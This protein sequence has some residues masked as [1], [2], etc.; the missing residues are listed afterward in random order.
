MPSP[1]D[2]ERDCLQRVMQFLK[3]RV[4]AEPAV[5]RWRDHDW[6]ESLSDLHGFRGVDLDPPADPD[7]K[8][9]RV[10]LRVAVQGTTPC[11]A[12]PPSLLPWLNEGWDDPNATL[13]VRDAIQAQR[14][15]QGTSPQLL[16]G[17]TESAGADR[18]DA[19]PARM[20]ALQQWMLVREQWCKLEAPVRRVNSLYQRLFEQYQ[21]LRRAAERFGF[22]IGDFLLEVESEGRPRICHPVVRQRC[23][24]HYDAAKQQLSVVEADVPL[25]VSVDVLAALGCDA[26]AISDTA[27]QLKLNSYGLDDSEVGG[28]VR[29]LVNPVFTS[30]V[31]HDGDPAGGTP[32]E[33]AEARVR[34]SR[35]GFVMTRSSGVVEA[36]E[37]LEGRMEGAADVSSALL[38]ILIDSNAAGANLSERGRTGTASGHALLVKEANREQEAIVHALDRSGS[39]VVQGPPG[40]GKT[41][42]IA[43]VLG[44][45]LAQ[46]KSVLVTSHTSKA[47]RVLRD[48][49]PS[50]LQPLCVSILDQDAQSKQQLEQSVTGIISRLTTAKATYSEREQA[51]DAKRLRL[52]ERVR[53]LEVR[54]RDAMFRD[55]EPIVV[56]TRKWEP[57]EAAKW[58]AEQGNSF[59]WIPQPLVPSV[60]MPLSKEE[61]ESLYAS[62]ASLSPA[63]EV[64]L[65]QRRPHT[66]GLLAPD[67]VVWLMQRLV[68]LQPIAAGHRPELWGSGA[69]ASRDILESLAER[70]NAAGAQ[71]AASQGLAAACIRD[72]RTGGARRMLWEEY[73]NEATELI[74]QVDR[75]QFAVLRSQPQIAVQLSPEET[76][77]LLEELA[78]HVD[79]G[80]KL[81]GVLFGIKCLRRTNL[82][83]VLEA[84]SVAGSPPRAR[85]DFDALKALVEAGRARKRLV[86]RW[87][88]QVVPAGGPPIPDAGS[89]EDFLRERVPQ[90]REYVRWQQ[91]RF[92]SVVAEARRAGLDWSG[93]RRLAGIPDGASGETEQITRL[94]TNI[95]P[96]VI[97]AR[98]AADEV[99]QVR[100]RLVEAMDLLRGFQG[101]PLADSMQA[102][103]ANTDSTRYR[104][105]FTELGRLETLES[106]RARRSELLEKLAMAA[107]GWSQAVRARRVGFD[108]TAPVENAGQCWDAAQI[109]AELDRRGAID[110]M[111]TIAELSAALQELRQATSDLVENRSWARQHDR[112]NTE[113]RQALQGWMT[114]VNMPG[115]RTGKRSDT[116]QREAKK[117]LA[118]CRSA[119]PI[120]VMP[121]ARVFETYDF[122]SVHFDVVVVDEASQCDLLG[123]AAIAIGAQVMVVGDD[124]QVSPSA[125]GEHLDSSDRAI[126]QYLEGISNKH[127]FTGRLSLYAMASW[128]LGQPHMLTEH[129]RCVDDIIEFSN[130]LSYDG[131]ILP[132][133]DASDV[134]TRPHV[135]EHRAPKGMRS[136]TGK[137][138]EG[139]ANE[140]AQIIEAICGMPEYAEKSLGVISMLGE[141]QV[142]VLDREI[143]KVLS[144]SDYEARKVLCGIPPHFQ[145]DER[146]V[147][148]LSL[149]DSTEPGSPLRSNGTN[150]DFKK[151]YNV[152]ASRAR[153]QLWVVHSLNT[154]TDLKED[155]L[156]RR[157]IEHARD[158]SA[159]KR[160]RGAVAQRAESPFELEVGT[161]L[162]ARGYRL[163]PQYQV[164]AFRI[165]FVAVGRNCRVAIE[166]DGD[167]YHTIDELAADLDRQRI[168]ERLGW[169]F[170][171]IRG[172]QYY[173][174]KAG[175]LDE[176]CKELAKLGVAPLG[177]DESVG[178]GCTSAPERAGVGSGLPAEQVLARVRMREVG[179]YSVD[180]AEDD[181]VDEEPEALDAVRDMV[182]CAA[183]PSLQEVVSDNA[184]EA[185]GWEEVQSAPVGEREVEEWVAR[186]R[187]HLES[188]DRAMARQEVLDETG[189]PADLWRFVADAAVSR[190]L[191]RRTGNKRGTRYSLPVANAR[192]AS[193]SA[194]P[195]DPV[196]AAMHAIEQALVAIGRPA[197][198]NEI[199]D[200]IGSHARHWS[201]ALSELYRRKR[202]TADRN[203]PG[204]WHKLSG[205][206]P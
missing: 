41:H 163:V 90:I 133:R 157:L 69:A 162:V 173:R 66:S 105:V 84:S 117:L 167:R 186:F 39:V 35:V 178:P 180:L 58:I 83:V 115:Y 114:T 1:T 203:R 159:S 124:K 187:R 78:V 170:V 161:A 10:F 16:F 156:R 130:A 185:T 88:A 153:D 50:A 152:A 81:K 36:L 4:A 23:E 103:L 148:L 183:I 189:M 179:V 104:A 144:T 46:G 7:W 134:K 194:V 111:K 33:T 43:N 86:G 32:G 67:D 56:G 196:E 198:K 63:D 202:V 19:D 193:H 29:A 3:A 34:R 53:D 61:L 113:S 71:L 112:I 40:T 138:N 91:D 77:D 107:P 149:V 97:E 96:A 20:R 172:G 150:D 15:A 87:A 200:R 205:S 129:F 5:L 121:L 139:E 136:S 74:E 76:I 108:G 68:R 141:E 169:R 177:P 6:S 165:D 99:R 160:A 132:L 174:N 116:L 65:Q 28:L 57:L 154:Q 140:I 168:L 199:T 109:A 51:A 106:T 14:R 125:V 8:L 18:F 2:Y 24:L 70:S 137:T 155:D 72:G 37:A 45:L 27:R 54:L 145:G 89:A 62:N 151:R 146:D 98:L 123:L 93:L 55:L 204:V 176:V 92:D 182:R 22:Y 201:E 26:P 206:R 110:V 195:P 197:S 120:W 184:S 101:Q 85:A 79:A 190:G 52:L 122:S 11:P 95:L 158:P 126:R 48:K 30:R 166:C 82:K 188:S 191:V 80:G 64:L 49:L 119:V 192:G 100:V 38:D 73:C 142:L 181:E 17:G 102:S 164:G 21:Q 25:E 13:A 59:C 147:V 131:R 31:H 42:T 12:P 127:L 47:L 75:L 118:K 175:T 128:G 44:H 60:A 143:R 94:L 135:V 9:G 171:R